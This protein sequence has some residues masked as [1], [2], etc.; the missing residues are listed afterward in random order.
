M[1]DNPQFNQ[2][3]E[4]RNQLGMNGN[5][6]GRFVG[7]SGREIQPCEVGD[8]GKDFVAMEGIVVQKEGELPEQAEME[9]RVPA[10][11]FEDEPHR[12]EEGLVEGG[13]VNKALRENGKQGESRTRV[14]KEGQK[15]AGNGGN[16]GS[17]AEKR[18]GGKKRPN[19]LG[20][21]MRCGILEGVSRRYTAMKRLQE[22][23]VFLRD[24]KSNQLQLLHCRLHHLCLAGVQKQHDFWRRR[25]DRN[26]VDF[27]HERQQ[28]PHSTLLFAQREPIAHFLHSLH[29]RL[30]AQRAAHATN[31]A[32]KAVIVEHVAARKSLDSLAEKTET[33]FRHVG[34]RG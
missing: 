30:E 15:K 22:N 1:V 27:V 20:V 26:R 28:A 9:G 24:G 6:H 18:E 5:D 21:T 11:L 14:A 29:L 8:E 32:G 17:V 34:W 7:G 23:G 19:H 2:V 33:Q 31:P 4:E 16:G 3:R 12:D 13:G 25:Q 10:K